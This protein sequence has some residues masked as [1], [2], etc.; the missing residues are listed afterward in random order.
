[1]GGA[2]ITGGRVRIRARS[3]KLVMDAGWINGNEVVYL[4]R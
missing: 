3:V 1:M 4:Y 2:T